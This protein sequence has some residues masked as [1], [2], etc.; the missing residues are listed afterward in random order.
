MRELKAQAGLDFPGYVLEN[1]EKKKIAEIYD[2]AWAVSPYLGVTIDV[3]ATRKGYAVL[4]ASWHYGPD[5]HGIIK[6][7]ACYKYAAFQVKAEELSQALFNAIKTLFIDGMIADKEF[8]ERQLKELRDEEYSYDEKYEE[9]KKR[10]SKWLTDTIKATEER[11]RSLEEKA[12]I[13]A[14]QSALAIR[15]RDFERLSAITLELPDRLQV[16]VN[17]YTMRRLSWKAP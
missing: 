8:L 16:A 9:Y 17:L 4:A 11:I 6:K 12:K 13:W 3:Y 14:E 5:R 1:L 10:Q 7:W 15:A 2:N